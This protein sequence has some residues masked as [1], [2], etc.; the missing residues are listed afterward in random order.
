MRR[1]HN[2]Y[3]RIEESRRARTELWSLV[4]VTVLLG[5]LLGVLTNGLSSL[6]ES[7]LPEPVWIGA[8]VLVGTSSILLTLAAIWLLYGQTD[9]QRALIDL[10]LPYHFPA[11]GKVTI[12]GKEATSYQPPRHAQRPFR[13]RYRGNSPALE[14]FLEAFAQAQAQ[15]QVFQDL[16]AA[17]HLALTQC[18]VLYVIH[19]YGEET[20]GAEAPYSWWQ[21]AMPA[22][23]LPMDELPSPLRDNPFLRVDQK[24]D[25]WR[26]L[27]P[28]PVTFSVAE[29]QW[30]LRHPL[31][32]RVVVHWLPRLLAIGPGSQPFEALTTRMRLGEDS[33]LYVV[34]SRIEASAELRYTLLPS[35]EPFQNWATGLLAC[36][37]EALDFVYYIAT[38]P[39]RVVR[40]LEWKIGWVPDGTSIVDILQSIEGRLEALET[41]EAARALD[42]VDEEE[43]PGADLVV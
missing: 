12:P 20:L 36:L 5:F 32:G 8:L 23:H 10:W 15:G 11:P 39:D 35:S 33:Q 2:R 7:A 31:Y 19:R 3:S 29:S 6:L 13:K 28:K 41:R 40:D 21:V 27:L 42:A 9:S 17:D 18:L 30:V 22:K 24:P 16:I 34:G 14:S 38:R 25:E 37:E 1:R 43:G 4:L 26:L